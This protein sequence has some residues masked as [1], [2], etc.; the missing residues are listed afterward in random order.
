MPPIIGVPV[1]DGDLRSRDWLERYGRHVCI[2]IHEIPGR[3]RTSGSALRFADCGRFAIRP[4][5][6]IVCVG[7]VF[8]QNDSFPNTFGG[9]CYCP[10]NPEQEE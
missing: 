8:L 2:H 7:C 4:A 1:C 6:S 3:C 9:P 10:N 5:V